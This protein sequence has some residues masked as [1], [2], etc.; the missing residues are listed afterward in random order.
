[1]MNHLARNI[2]MKK[3]KSTNKSIDF[4][5]C[6]FWGKMSRICGWQEGGGLK[7]GLLRN[8][9]LKGFSANCR[10]SLVERLRLNTP[11]VRFGFEGVSFK[12]DFRGFQ[13]G[14]GLFRFKSI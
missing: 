12:D 4:G 10:P 6:V 13:V 14:G 8:Q 11:K 1:M 9:G 2:N 7:T 5:V 3:A